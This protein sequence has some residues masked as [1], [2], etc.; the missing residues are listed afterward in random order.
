MKTRDRQDYSALLVAENTYHVFNRTNNREPMF[1]DDAGRRHFLQKYAKYVSPYVDTFAYC[2]LGNHFH[3]LVRVKCLEDILSAIENTPIEERSGAQKDILLLPEE[4]RNAHPVLASQFMRLFTSH[5]MYIN[6]KWNRKGNLFHR[7]FKR[8]LI[9][10]ERYFEQL[11]YYIHANPTKHGICE[12]FTRYFWS[13]YQSILSEGPT[14]L[15]REELLEWFGGKRMFEI[16]HQQEH[17]LEEVGHFLIE[18]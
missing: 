6:L 16:F 8:I 5:S 7:P 14:R 12:D 10:S 4:E 11:V 15:E 17:D 18:D 2:L 3:L 1:Y 13:S 9:D